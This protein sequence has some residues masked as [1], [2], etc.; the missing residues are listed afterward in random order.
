MVITTNR[1][2]IPITFEPDQAPCAVNSFVALATQGYF[3]NTSCHRLTTEGYYVLQCGDPLGTGQG[4]PGYSFKDELLDNDPRL[5][6]CGNAGGQAYCTYGTGT[7][8]MANRGPNTNGSQFFLVYG[9]SR[10]PP[11]FTVFGHLDASGLKVIKAIAA[12]GI[13]TPS[14]MGP[15]DGAPKEPVTITSVK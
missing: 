7:V 10:F 2:T 5:Q 4:G 1:G 13:G 14:G 8:A 9:S 3:D 11:D 15:G 6:P 12:K